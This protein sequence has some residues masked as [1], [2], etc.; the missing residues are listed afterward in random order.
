[1]V[2]DPSSTQIASVVVVSKHEPTMQAIIQVIMHSI[3]III[4]VE[5]TLTQPGLHNT[6]LDCS[7]AM[8]ELTKTNPQKCCT[9]F[10]QNYPLLQ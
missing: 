10:L 2:K 9:V 4:N 8:M 3:I 7:F 5:E 6:N 1:M